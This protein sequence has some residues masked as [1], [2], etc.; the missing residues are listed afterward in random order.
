MSIDHGSVQDYSRRGFGFVSRTLTSVGHSDS[1]V[2]FHIKTVRRKY[3]ELAD[4][5]DRGLHGG[6]SFWYEAE[7]SAK[8]Q[9]V[10]ELWLKAEEMPEAQRAEARTMLERL[11]RD[12][13]GALPAGLQKIAQEVLGREDYDRL[14][15]ELE[16]C[17]SEKQQAHATGELFHAKVVRRMTELIRAKMVRPTAAPRPAVPP[18]P[19]TGGTRPTPAPRHPPVPTGAQ[20]NWWAQQLRASGGGQPSAPPGPRV[21]E[22]RVVGVTYEGRQAVVAQL[23]VGEQVQ[24]RRE[25]ANPHDPNAIRVERQNG[26]QIGYISRFEAAMFAPLLDAKG[27]LLPATVTDLTGGYSALSSRGVKIRFTLPEAGSSAP[28]PIRDFDDSWEQ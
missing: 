13:Q 2:F 18:A 25:P 4:K 7:P 26:Q 9:Q 1:K 20:E 17:L 14:H 3:P 24:L 27:G 28:P 6:V 15:G 16:R 12:R 22:T 11:L 10:R 23:S 19:P 8:G 5:L 21:I